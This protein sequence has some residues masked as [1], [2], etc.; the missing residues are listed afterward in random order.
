MHSDKLENIDEA[1]AYENPKEN[2]HAEIEECQERSERRNRN[3]T[4]KGVH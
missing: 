1:R 3:L 4:E 2:S